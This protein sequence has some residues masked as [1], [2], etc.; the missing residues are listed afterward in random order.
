MTLSSSYH[1]RARSSLGVIMVLGL[2]LLFALY[3]LLV[4]IGWIYSPDFPLNKPQEQASVREA[5]FDHWL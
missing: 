1:R 2:I 5:I 4:L 3:A